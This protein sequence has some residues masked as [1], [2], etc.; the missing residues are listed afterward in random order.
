M[1]VSVQPNLPADENLYL[2]P[3]PSTSVTASAL[4]Q[5]IRH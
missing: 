5:I 3:L 1:M 2:Q 4:P